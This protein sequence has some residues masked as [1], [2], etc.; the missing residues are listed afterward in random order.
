MSVL[1]HKVC[2]SFVV[3]R[4]TAHPFIN[5]LALFPVHKRAVHFKLMT[6]LL[7]GDEK[8]LAICKDSVVMAVDRAPVLNFAH[9]DVERIQYRNFHRASARHINKSSDTCS[10]CQTYWLRELRKLGPLV[11][12]DAV[13]FTDI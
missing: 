7:T 5:Y 12:N 6:V 4:G 2:S 1:G 3:D 8:I 13:A 10:A 9:L 11:V